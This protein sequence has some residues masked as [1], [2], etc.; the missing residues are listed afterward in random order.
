MS[1]RYKGFKKIG[2]QTNAVLTVFV[3]KISY[4]SAKLLEGFKTF[5]FN[6]FFTMVFL[7]TC[8]WPENICVTKKVTQF[9]YY[10]KM[11]SLNIYKL[12][13]YI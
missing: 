10:E 1:K 5:L 3:K 7:Y 6:I 12:L 8:L 4:S 2:F 13:F 11:K 9:I